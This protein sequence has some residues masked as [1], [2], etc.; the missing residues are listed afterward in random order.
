[1][2]SCVNFDYDRYTYFVMSCSKLVNKLEPVFLLD[3]RRIPVKRRKGAP[4]KT[5][6]FWTSV[7]HILFGSVT[8]L[9][10]FMFFSKRFV[11]LQFLHWVHFLDKC[12]LSNLKLICQSVLHRSSQ[13]RIMGTGIDW[14][15]SVRNCLADFLAKSVWIES[16]QNY[17]LASSAVCFV[18]YFIR[19]PIWI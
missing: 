10:L 16:R 2:P 13:S 5:T 8:S 19:R 18:L 14:M 9:F 15:Q 4:Q 3:R 17:T 12:T 1:M 6:F 11:I 7:A